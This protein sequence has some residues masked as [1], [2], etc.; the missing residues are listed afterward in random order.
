M[1]HAKC[2]KLNSKAISKLSESEDD[3]FCK[4]CLQDV[5]PFMK[6]TNNSIINLSFNSCHTISKPKLCFKC[7][8]QIKD[9]LTNSIYCNSG[10]H[11]L[12]L[13]CAS[14]NKTKVK[15]V[16]TGLWNCNDCNPFPFIDLNNIDLNIDTNFNSLSMPM[17]SKVIHYKTDNSFDFFKKLPKLEI[18]PPSNSPEDNDEADTLSSLDFEYYNLCDFEKMTKN[19]SQDKSMSI[20]H[21]NIRSYSKNMQSFMIL[22]SDLQYEFDIIGLTETWQNINKKHLITSELLPNYQT[23]EYI[24]GHT[25][26]SGCG[27]YVKQGIHY[28]RRDDLSCSY[29]ENNCEYEILFIEIHCEKSQNMLVGVVYR[30]PTK[31]V[32]PFLTKLENILDICKSEKKE[33]VLM[34]DFNLDLLKS[35]K[36][37][38]ISS[39]LDIML[40]KFLQPHI[41]QPT[42]FFDDD[43][44]SLIDNIFYNQIEYNCTSGN[45][46]PHISDHLVNFLIINKSIS[47][48]TSKN[49][50]MRDYKHFDKEVFLNELTGI[51]VKKKLE[52]N[53]ANSKYNILHD[54]IDNLLNKH[55]PLT[56]MSNKKIKQMRKPWI[57]DNILKLIGQ[58]NSLYSQH[59]QTG[60]H[61]ILL[62]YRTLRNNINHNI[63]KNKYLYYSAYFSSCNNN[64]RKFW[65]G[66]NNF[67]NNKNK[68]ND[69]PLMINKKGKPCTE[70]NDIASE[71][72]SYFT[73][74]APS[75]VK[76]LPKQSN[77]KIFSDYLGRNNDNSFFLSPTTSTEVC[78]TIKKLDQNKASDIYNFPV[79]IIKDICEIISSPLSD[80]I[81]ESFS[82]G[83]FP[84][85]LK[86]AKVIPL[87]KGN[88][89]LETKNYRPISILPIFDKI[90]EKL[91]YS[92]LISF[93]TKHTILSTCQYGFRENHST[94]LAILDLISKVQ[95]STENGNLSCV[96]FLDFAK[97]F[98]TVNHEILLKKLL[99]YG[100]RGKAHEWFASYLTDR[101]QSVSVAGSLSEPL[102]I[103]CGVPQ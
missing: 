100:I 91:M 11:H 47:I 64:I 42:K 7:H 102:P 71:F 67:L 97:A 41:I 31:N 21:T 16:N 58:K 86:L 92:R 22:L 8:V 27:L 25:Q 76:K 60:N 66:I 15:S 81:N 79:K 1:L 6:E 36:N 93:L 2:L 19:N 51:D 52:K 55:A 49:K 87:H 46:I 62:Q 103:K 45:L 61:D 26:N 48:K 43:N 96:I 23:Y 82:T 56:K 30:H 95:E 59:L 24:C 17:I 5:L 70:P 33:I 101:K 75:L 90:I 34:G 83:V 54:T 32:L 40:T 69:T 35:D 4:I 10:K 65:K 73:N 20:I 88:S 14:L 74:V 38:D 44:Y 72:N 89:K 80:I 39:F 94:N 12:H 37:N 85:R 68:D 50:I 28:D 84:E 13:K 9:H 63:R 29:L 99:H 77:K 53:G 18:G 78:N 57:S 98:D 3:W